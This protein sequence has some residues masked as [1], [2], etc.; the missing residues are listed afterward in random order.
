MEASALTLV[1]MTGAVYLLMEAGKYFNWIPEES[2]HRFKGFLSFGVAIAVT[3]VGQYIADPLA[4]DFSNPVAGLEAFFAWAT[5]AWAGATALH[6][7]LKAFMEKV[8]SGEL[9]DSPPEPEE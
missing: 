7:Q 5:V 4:V 9:L 3:F 6:H 8:E 2:T 1:F